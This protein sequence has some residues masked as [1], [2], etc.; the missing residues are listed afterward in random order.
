[1]SYLH[2]ERDCK[3][4]KREFKEID[5]I[6]CWGCLIHP[7]N[8]A[9]HTFRDVQEPVQV[10][11]CCNTSPMPY[12]TKTN[13]TRQR[14]P[15]YQHEACTKADHFC[16][17]INIGALQEDHWPA[18]LTQRIKEELALGKRRPGLIA[19][20]R[21]NSSNGLMSN[22]TLMRYNTTPDRRPLSADLFYNKEYERAY[23]RGIVD[24]LSTMAVT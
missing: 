14:N 16:T 12:V 8:L 9:G 22:V 1:M 6:G 7:G 23:S 24:A 2:W 18:A 4:C 17:Q 10:W 15:L 21:I 11:S 20:T 19:T 3:Q 5:N 13:G